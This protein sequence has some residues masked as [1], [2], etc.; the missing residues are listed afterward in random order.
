MLQGDDA[1]IASQLE[2]AGRS[3]AIARALA[4]CPQE[5]PDEDGQGNRYCLDCAEIIPSARVQA[6][7]AVRCV[8]CTRK[9]ERLSKKVSGSDIRRYLVE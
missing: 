2:E 3:A 5:E 8:D 7:R 4:A 1:E 9:K 6:V